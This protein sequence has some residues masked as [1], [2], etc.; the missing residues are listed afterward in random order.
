M[1]LKILA[2]YFLTFCLRLQLY[3]ATNLLGM[4]GYLFKD[5]LQEQNFLNKK[6]LTV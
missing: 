3:Y 6:C 4:T 2:N 1:S 5:R